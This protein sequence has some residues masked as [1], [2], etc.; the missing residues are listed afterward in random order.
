MANVFA[1]PCEVG[2]PGLGQCQLTLGFCAKNTSWR[3]ASGKF[4]HCS[5]VRPFEARDR[6]DGAEL[7]GGGEGWD[8]EGVEMAAAS[9]SVSHPPSQAGQPNKGYETLHPLSS[10]C[11]AKETHCHFECFFTP[12][13]PLVVS[14][15]PQEPAVAISALWVHRIG[16]PIPVWRCISTGM[17]YSTSCGRFLADGGLFRVTSVPLP[18]GKPQQPL[19]VNPDLRQDIASISPSLSVQVDQTWL[20]VRILFMLT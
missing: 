18:R 11:R 5:V 2:V 9:A 7:D 15:Q 13:R 19:L 1:T 14:Q 12:R 4:C 8:R 17:E 20:G 10:R 3:S 6:Q 16:L